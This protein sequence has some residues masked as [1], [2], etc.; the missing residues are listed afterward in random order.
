MQ[1]LFQPSLNNSAV[2]IKEDPPARYHL[3]TGVVIAIAIGCASV[4]LICAIAAFILLRRKRALSM[5]DGARGYKAS[6]LIGSDAAAE[7]SSDGQRAELSDESLAELS[8]KVHI[9]EM[10]ASDCS[11]PEMDTKPTTEVIVKERYVAE[12]AAPDYAPAKKET[13]EK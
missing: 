1:A 3:K 5:E 7:M 2:S 6:E 9:V 10:A 11:L 4:F 12:L 13:L 8:D